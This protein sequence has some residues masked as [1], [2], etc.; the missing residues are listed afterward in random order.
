M[1][2]KG[3]AL[4]E[5]QQAYDEFRSKIAGLPPAAWDDVW[6]GS[7][8]LPQLLAHMAGWWNE[9]LPAFDRVTRGE[10]PLPEGVDYSDPDS[11][12]A[13]FADRA[14]TGNEA[15]ARWDEAFRA[16]QEAAGGLADALFG[17]NDQG[18][19]KI[20]NRLLQGAGSDH[21]AEHQ[22]DLDSWVASR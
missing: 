7:W 20:G 8:A 18:R 2:T 19:P 6:L 1:A 4:A 21:F 12:N 15:L 9:M 5:L 11:F 13:R 3:E 10:R 14:P 16:Y 17:E 22:E